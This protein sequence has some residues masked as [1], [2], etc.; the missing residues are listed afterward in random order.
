MRLLSLELLRAVGTC[1]PASVG[2]VRLQLLR[3][4][5]MVRNH[6]SGGFFDGDILRFLLR[7]LARVNQDFE[8]RGTEDCSNEQSSLVNRPP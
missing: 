4:L 2:R 7:E 5:V 1:T 3:A 8:I 6:L